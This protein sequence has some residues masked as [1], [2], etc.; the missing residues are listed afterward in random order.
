MLYPHTA[1]LLMQSVCALPLITVFFP[2]L[3]SASTHGS[4]LNKQDDHWGKHKNIKQQLNPL[5]LS[6]CPHISFLFSLPGRKKKKELLAALAVIT[7]WRHF[8]KL[9]ICSAISQNDKFSVILTMFFFS[10][11]CNPPWE[12]RPR[13][14]GWRRPYLTH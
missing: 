14:W 7:S 11:I 9:I 1:E 4:I 12:K 3:H 13:H 10:V 6:D 5:V 2:Q 8:I